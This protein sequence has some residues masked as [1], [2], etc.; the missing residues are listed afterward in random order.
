MANNVLKSN[1]PFVRVPANLVQYMVELTLPIIPLLAGVRYAKSNPELAGKLITRGILGMGFLYLADALIEAG[2]VIAGG[3]GDDEKERALKY[4]GQKPNTI[5]VSLVHRL[6]AGIHDPEN[7]YRKGDKYVEY[8]KLGPL[9]I[10]MVARAKMRENIAQGSKKKSPKDY[11][12][13]TFFTQS[14]EMLNAAS[15]STM[16]LSFLQGTSAL[17]DAIKDDSLDSYMANLGNTMMAIPLPNNL[18]ATT[19]AR[20]TEMVRAR[21]YDS[22]WND[23]MEK[24]SIKWYPNQKDNREGVYPV[25]GMWGKMV[26]Q[27]PKSGAYGEMSPLV[28][29]YFD[30]TRSGVIE[31]PLTI[32]IM[33]LSKR[34]N[35]FVIGPPSVTTELWDE[36][37]EKVNVR[38]D[39]G[40]HVKAQ[41]IAGEL[42]RMD[43]MSFMNEEEYATMAD[44]EK[45][46]VIKD[47]SNRANREA[48]NFVTDEIQKQL[49]EKRGV[50]NTAEKR[51][52]YTK[53]NRFDYEKT[54][55]DLASYLNE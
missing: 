55:L 54:M 45:V 12:E 33:N 4:E 18:I 8:S 3:E 22:V 32:E 53:F 31:D 21:D 37:D 42:K 5:N 34:T 17:L 19:M 43:I 1:I 24:Q 2:A 47:I 15:R 7:P 28:R 30:I 26:E 49:D 10:A 39:E 36:N 35:E 38:M 46:E 51:Y 40:D 20:R 6:R 44:A 14:L 50:L 11:N 48:V 25:I 29:Q 52:S 16:E 23:F 13:L 9:G 27:N 41:I